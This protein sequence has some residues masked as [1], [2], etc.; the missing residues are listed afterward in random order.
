MLIGAH[1]TLLLDIKV[2]QV[3]I[4]FRNPAGLT[5]WILQQ[6]CRRSC[7]TVLSLSLHSSALGLWMGPGRSRGRH[8]S[9]RLR[10]AKGPTAGGGEELRHCGLQG[11]SP[12]WPGGSQTRGEFECS[13]SSAALL[14][15]PAQPPQLLARVLSLSLPWAG[16]TGRP[17]RVRG[18]QSPRKHQPELTLA[19][20]PRQQP[21]SRPRLSLHTSQQAEGGGSSLSQPREGL[22]QCPGGLKGSSSASRVDVEAEEAPRVRAASTLLTSTGTTGMSHCAGPTANF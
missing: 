5:Q 13:P 15:D 17:L 21:R 6:G 9:R 8:P 3:P 19:P 20:E 2:L 12:A 10:S 4:Q 1:T 7:P 18:P 14:G 16:S 11:S 22:P